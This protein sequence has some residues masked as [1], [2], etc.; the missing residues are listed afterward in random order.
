MTF[1]SNNAGRLIA[2]NYAAHLQEK[3]A[4]WAKDLRT[5]RC[6]TLPD[7]ARAQL[8]RERAQSGQLATHLSHQAR[9]LI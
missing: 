6:E 3:L 2:S 7:D 9:R 4:R 1:L 5:R 8:T